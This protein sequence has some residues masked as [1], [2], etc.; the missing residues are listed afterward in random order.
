MKKTQAILTIT[1]EGEWSQ[2]MTDDDHIYRYRVEK[3]KSAR[4]ECKHCGEKILQGEYR[5]GSPIKWRQ[6]IT[7]WRHPKCFFLEQDELPLDFSERGEVYG[8]NAVEDVD[9]LS[10]LCK[11]LSKSGASEVAFDPLKDADV[12]KPKVDVMAKIEKLKPPTQLTV[13]L[14][15]Y[16]IEGFSWMVFKEASMDRGGILGDEMGMGKTLQTLCAIVADKNKMNTSSSSSVKKPKTTL[17]VSPSSAMLQWADEIQRSFSENTL[18]LLVF[19]S[20]SQRQKLTPEKL[21]SYDV[22]LTSYPIVEHDYRLCVNSL[23]VACQYCNK[24]FLQ[25]K[26]KSHLKYFCGPFAA[27]S[28]KLQKTERTRGTD[29]AMETLGITSSSSSN[30]NRRSEN[31][32]ENFKPTPTGIYNELMREA[33]RIPAPMHYSAAFAASFSAGSGKEEAKVTETSNN[34]SNLWYG[35]KVGLFYKS[36]RHWNFVVKQEEKRIENAYDWLEKERKENKVVLMH[37][38]F[39]SILLHL[40]EKNFEVEN[41]LEVF[42]KKV[43]G[44]GSFVLKQNQM[45]EEEEEEEE[46]DEK[47]AGVGE[48]VLRTFKKKDVFGVVTAKSVNLNP[49][50]F[51]VLHYDGDEEELE[52]SEVKDAKDLLEKKV[53]SKKFHCDNVEMSEELKQILFLKNEKKK[54]ILVDLISSEDEKKEEEKKKKQSE[55]KTSTKSKKKEK[56]EEEE[57]KK[58]TTR[59][60]NISFAQYFSD[61][62]DFESKKSFSSSSLE[63]SSSS[64]SVASS[65]GRG[66]RGGC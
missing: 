8:L 29:K 48:V 61:E 46:W 15:P 42:N 2:L 44:K 18:S 1:A 10:M 53:K 38:N 36:G 13:T 19:E 21:L 34:V 59:G 26:L 24:K 30:N 66:A 4:A 9:D 41:Q 39:P 60:K 20:G 56:K 47:H 11:E 7:S 32:N 50:L 35:E 45:K 65:S 63:I 58:R 31:E 16:Q 64:S 57:A 51:R 17:I 27:R 52:V 40:N 28:A 55:K 12:I 25:R 14:L 62:S 54:K 49:V 6:W 22:V 33:N 3:A 5:V 23:K 43:I 37:A